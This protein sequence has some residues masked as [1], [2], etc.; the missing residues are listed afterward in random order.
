[1]AA[2]GMPLLTSADSARAAATVYTASLLATLPLLLAAIGSLALRRASP[3]ARAL[4]WRSA[5]VALV[6]ISIGRLLPLH[7]MSWVVPSG[8]AAPLVALGRIQV[9]T[10]AMRTADAIMPT[11]PSG[12][13]TSVV[14]L[15]LAAYVLGVLVVLLPTVAASLRIRAMTRRHEREH[16]WHQPADE[17]QRRLGMRRRVRIVCASGV[18]I[19]MTCGFLRPV[20]VLPESARGWTK[21]QL[22]IVLV[23]EL[24]HVRSADWLFK[25]TARVVCALY[26]FHPGVWWI[27]RRLHDDCELACEALVIASGVRR[28]YYAELLVY[29]VDRVWQARS[30]H[31]T[32]LGLSERAGLRARLA[33]VLDTTRDLRP[34]RRAWLAVAASVTVVVAVPTGSVQLAP[35]RDVLTTLMRD[36]RWESRAYAVLGL[37]QR[38]DSVAVARSAAEL[39]PNPRV[40]AWAR[41]ALGERV[42]LVDSRTIR[43]N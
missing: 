38:P 43:P 30:M 36:P 24:S 13:I 40:R 7:G 20:V 18:S 27:A 14:N 34:V 35:T 25:M 37:A 4:V 15:L 42:D 22:R 17:V 21:E 39:D 1:M 31:A 8:I 2:S 3:E 23:H 29:A 11:G 12:G 41:Y 10:L 26:W 28:S 6:V 9:A 32:A 19:P 16:E 5:I 33:A